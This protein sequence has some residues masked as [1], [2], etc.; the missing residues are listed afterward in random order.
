MNKADSK[1]GSADSEVLDKPIN[2][3]FIGLGSN[4]NYPLQKVTQ[5]ISELAKLPNTVLLASSSCYSNPPLPSKYKQDNFIN[6]V[7][8]LQTKLTPHGLLHKLWLIEQKY[9]RTR[10]KELRWGPRN[11][12]LDILLFNN[13][14]LSEA[15][16]TIPHPELKKRNFV[17]YPLYEIEPDL[18]LPDGQSILELTKVLSK[19]HLVIKQY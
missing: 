4:L 16:L 15:N 7:V 17:V 11:L 14:V 5:A 18:V 6:A 1:L 8:K 13:L 19:E 9:G 12:D 3:A 10:S 2:I